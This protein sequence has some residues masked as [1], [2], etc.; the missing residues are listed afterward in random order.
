MINKT[1]EYYNQ[2]AESYCSDTLNADMSYSRDEFTKYVKKDGTILDLGCG[3]GRDSKEFIKK[4][5]KVIAVDGSKKLCE[6]ASKYIGQEVICS[7]FEEYE[8]NEHFD[9]LW[10]CSSLLHIPKHEIKSFMK[11][12]IPYL[13]DGAIIYMSYKYGNN[14]EEKNG[15]YF[16]NF[17]EQSINELF[18][19]FTELKKI[20]EEITNDVRPGRTDEK[21]LNEYYKKV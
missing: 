16:V 2:N 19:D 20:K 3:T 9:G 13:N 6:F 1:I 12:I 17:D 21:W 7:T 14:A 10:A 5:F 18:K 8:P 15:R 4:G 11:K